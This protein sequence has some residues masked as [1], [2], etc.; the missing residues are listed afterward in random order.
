MRSGTEAGC[1]FSFLAHIF[2]CAV[3]CEKREIAPAGAQMH[4]RVGFLAKVY[5]NTGAN[6]MGD[7]V[8]TLVFVID[9]RLYLF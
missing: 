4:T 1:P 2:L 5:K 3:R 7:A 9:K 6:S 8:S